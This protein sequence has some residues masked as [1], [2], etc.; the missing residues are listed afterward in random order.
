[1]RALGDSTAG[2]TVL[3]RLKGDLIGSLDSADKADA[4]CEI[5]GVVRA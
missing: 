2:E 5:L 4:E 1:M 3:S